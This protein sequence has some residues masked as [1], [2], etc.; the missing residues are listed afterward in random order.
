VPKLQLHRV[1]MVLVPSGTDARASSPAQ[2]ASAGTAP[3]PPLP[4]F[5]ARRVWA[6]GGGARLS[7]GC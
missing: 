4:A 6:P 2:T 5:S 1:P 3:P 7:H